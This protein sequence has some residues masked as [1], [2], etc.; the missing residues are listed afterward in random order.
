MQFN[1]PV[2]HGRWGPIN[3]T[4]ANDLPIKRTVFAAY[5]QQIIATCKRM[6]RARAWPASG[7]DGPGRTTLGWFGPVPVGPVR[8]GSA[9]QEWTTLVWTPSDSQCC[10]QTLTSRPRWYF[11]SFFVETSPLRI[12]HVQPTPGNRAKFVSNHFRE[13]ITGLT[14]T[15]RIYRIKFFYQYRECKRQS[16]L[17]SSVKCTLYPSHIY[18]D[19]FPIFV[20]FTLK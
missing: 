15:S 9:E 14:Y 4:V 8:V 6:A 17:L 16:T 5:R 1:I 7:R 11:F 10:T 2:G 12:C 19:L 20:T 13:R 3:V 18:W